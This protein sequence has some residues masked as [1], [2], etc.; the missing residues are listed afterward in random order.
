MNQSPL[1]ALADRIARIGRQGTDTAVGTFA[2]APSAEPQQLVSMVDQAI[3]AMDETLRRNEDRTVTALDAVARWMEHSSNTASQPDPALS[4]T[5]AL[6]VNRLED[7]DAKINRQPETAGASMRDAVARIENR[8]DALGKL[9]STAKANDGVTRSLKDLDQRLADIAKRLDKAPAIAQQPARSDHHV[10]QIESKLATIIET[11]GQQPRPAR[12]NAARIPGMPFSSHRPNADIRRAL[13]QGDLSGA[14]ADISARQK[15]LDAD[16]TRK[17][18]RA[19]GSKLDS[20][21]YRAR[22]S[23]PDGDQTA[24]EELKK[25]IATL[26]ERMEHTARPD[27]T[28]SV[29]ALQ[30]DLHS[31]SAALQ[32]LA[33][34]TQ[35]VAIENAVAALTERIA[36]SRDS[37]VNERLLS[38][39]ETQL[40]D[41]RLMLESN[42]DSEN[43]LEIARDIQAMKRRMENVPDRTV[44]TEALRDLQSQTTEIRQYV[45]QSAQKSSGLEALERRIAAIAERMEQAAET[46]PNHSMLADLGKRIDRVHRVVETAPAS[47]IDLNPLETMVQKLSARID[48]IASA[49]TPTRDLESAIKMLERKLDGGLPFSSSPD[50][51]GL[52]RTL[53]AKLDSRPLA[54]S[55]GEHDLAR[56]IQSIEQKIDSISRNALDTSQFDRMVHDLGLQ[57]E[58]AQAPGASDATLEALHQQVSRLASRLEQSDEHFASLGSMERTI[59]DIFSQLD[60]VKHASVEAAEAAAR[61][62]VQSAVAS[63]QGGLPL[64]DVKNLMQ[65]FGQ[66]KSAQDKTDRR[67]HETL[68]AVHETLETIVDRLGLLES[69]MSRGREAPLTAK[70][71]MPPA[72]QPP[73]PQE[74]AMFAPSVSLPEQATEASSLLY[75]SSADVFAQTPRDKDLTGVDKMRS[76]AS[77]DSEFDEPVS[78]WKTPPSSAETASVPTSAILDPDLPLEPGVGRPLGAAARD[79]FAK[80]AVEPMAPS[81]GDD[82]DNAGRMQAARAK[83]IESA[84][85]AAQMAADQSADVLANTELNEKT[86]NGS[87]KPKQFGRL[88]GSHKKPLLLGLAAIVFAAGGL[89]LY[90]ARS[91]MFKTVE[92]G[93]GTADADS[94][95]SRSLTKAPVTAARISPSGDVAPQLFA[96]AAK[97]PS[98]AAPVDATPVQTTPATDAKSSID[99]K[100]AKVSSASDATDPVYVGALPQRK[101]PSLVQPLAQQ[102]GGSPAIASINTTPSAEASLEMLRTEAATGNVKAQY[103]LGSRYIDGRGVTADSKQ[104]VQW[105]EKAAANGFAPAQYR[106]GSLYRDGKGLRNDGKLAYAWFK[107]AAE[108]GN[109]RA[110]HNL[111]VVMAEG[112]NG[113]PDYAGAAEWFRKG[114]EYGIKDSQFNVAILF[115]RG[116]G[117]AQDLIQSY[118]WFSAAAD[119]GDEDAAKKREEIAA[120]LSPEQL[121]EAKSAAQAFKPKAPDPL[122]NDLSPVPRPVVD[123][124]QAAVR[125]RAATPKS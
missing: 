73:M 39:L 63:F 68:E 89:S 101:L 85:R 76:K 48:E 58:R 53:T 66:V 43:L 21:M 123:A 60:S 109:A 6:L 119:L 54:E 40:S 71:A 36:E 5:L 19:L 20:Q 55:T 74:R 47:S 117:T 13:A 23:Q 12:Q 59:S 82:Q 32:D 112:S 25:Q 9:G 57:M 8:I 61:N 102:S 105:L 31:I 115:A 27:D 99:S 97:P 86:M 15:D 62:A 100:A 10:A 50:I 110:M 42:R 67:T 7:I 116:L 45:A 44:D 38:P 35:M 90:S 4:R 94:N 125:A 56:V 124:A 69:E 107:R 34:R 1:D 17:R 51:E 29:K 37:G 79:N 26:A 14:V 108:Q 95:Q 87:F 46:G 106:L 28:V 52:L 118:K 75:V 41:I 77:M 121:A 72:M 103:E 88:I 33:P 30:H 111:A 70:T 49:A 11:L 3:A 93:A 96:P 24:F 2:R 113:A 104:A 91:V 64:D 120:K 18:L 122:V 98:G 22:P 114:A 92:S 80:P 65:Q 83:F 16:T 81:A 78:S 84:R